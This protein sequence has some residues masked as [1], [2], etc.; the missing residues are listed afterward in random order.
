MR[1]ATRSASFVVPGCFGAVAFEFL[2]LVA[3]AARDPDFFLDDLMVMVFSSDIA[4]QIGAAT[5]AS[6]GWPGVVA[7]TLLCAG[8]SSAFARFGDCNSPALQ[9]VVFTLSSFSALRVGLILDPSR[10]SEQ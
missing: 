10:A 1:W 6:P 4:A 7:L 8:K 9:L 2:R 5:G 3:F